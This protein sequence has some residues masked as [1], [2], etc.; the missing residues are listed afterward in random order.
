[1]YMKNNFSEYSSIHVIRK[2]NNDDILEAVKAGT[3]DAALIGKS[4]F[5]LFQRDDE[6]CRVGTV[7]EKTLLSIQG[8]FALSVD[9]GTKCTS[10]IS[11]V[12]DLYMSEMKKDGFYDAAWD[13]VMESGNSK[14]IAKQES[15]KFKWTTE[16]VEPLTLENLSGIFLVHGFAFCLSIVIAVVMKY[17]STIKDGFIR[18]MYEGIVYYS[19]HRWGVY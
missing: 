7:S 3:C 6:D 17:G 15:A 2:S 18:E 1:M 14:C 5:R 10:L 19:E 9:A 16:E 11:Y 13:E 8:S 4:S 12:L